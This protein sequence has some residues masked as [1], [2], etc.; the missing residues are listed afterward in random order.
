ME[1]PTKLPTNTLCN[2]LLIII[3]QHS[4]RTSANSNV[5]SLSPEVSCKSESEKPEEKSKN[6]SD[7]TVLYDYLTGTGIHNFNEYVTIGFLGA[8][9]QAQVVLGALPLA[10]DAVNEDKGNA[11]SFI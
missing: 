8:Y 4:I 6:S 9:R 7:Y 3:L 1:V 5:S 2:L 11:E 10:V